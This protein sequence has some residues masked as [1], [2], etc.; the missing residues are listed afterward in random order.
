M[1]ASY[2]L[3]TFRTQPGV[4]SVTIAAYIGNLLRTKHAAITA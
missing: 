1:H 2:N 4:K 3:L